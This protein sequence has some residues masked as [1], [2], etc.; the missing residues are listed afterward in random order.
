MSAPV[1]W[2]VPGRIEVLGKHTD[3]AGGRVLVG[4]VDRGITATAEVV[5]GPVGSLTATT[6]AGGEP[7][8]L[9]VGTDPALPGGHW[10]RYL[11]T[12]LDRLAQ[13]FSCLCEPVAAHLTI[14][15]DLPPA[16]GMSSSS[17]LVCAS[18]LA[19]ADLNGWTA[20]DLWT[21]N[22]P[23]RLATAGYLAGVEAGRPWRELL[24]A[25][26]VGT[27]GGSE[28]HTG[29]LCGAPDTLLLARFAPMEVLTA[30]SFPGDWAFVVGVSGVAAEKTGTALADYNRGPLTLR[31]VLARWNGTTGRSDEFL[32]QAVASLIG[33]ATGEEAAADPALGALLSLTEPGYERRRV[34]QFLQ[35]SLVL[36]PA[37]AAAIAAGDTAV[38]EVLERS[39]ALAGSHLLNQVPQTDTLVSV[40]RQMGAL[41]ASAFGAGWGGS[42]YAIVPRGDADA[43][44]V[45]WLER[46]RAV[47]PEAGARAS[48]IVTRPGASAERLA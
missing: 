29:M 7:V 37:G 22:V 39:H 13:N 3:Y 34:E 32:A 40:A 44:A 18:A 33:E 8:S 41:G 35:E 45:E 27:Q 48:T 20:S 15:S 19:L 23:D 43:F 11:Q 14:T 21:R 2:R 6:T 17:A 30:V 26:G 16:S 4:A 5:D 47:F 12:V 10:G 25:E 28:D 46:Y 38:G 1:T 42:T 9:S 36:V 24:G 31:S